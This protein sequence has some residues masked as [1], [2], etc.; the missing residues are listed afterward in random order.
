M[1]RWPP[2]RGIQLGGNYVAKVNVFARSKAI[3]PTLYGRFDQTIDQWHENESSHDERRCSSEAPSLRV[4][5]E[6]IQGVFW[7]DFDGPGERKSASEHA[8]LVLRE[9]RPA[10]LNG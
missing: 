10:T 4:P 2:G 5:S 1:S 6:A 9:D 7:K 3:W 8:G